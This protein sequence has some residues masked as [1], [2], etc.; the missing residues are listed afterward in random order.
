MPSNTDPNNR[1]GRSIRLGSSG[2]FA[3]RPAIAI[4]QPIASCKDQR[5]QQNHGRHPGDG[6]VL[7][8]IVDEL[9]GD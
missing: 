3:R 4:K 5:A 2:I 6:L 9:E 8:S 7:Q 1:Q